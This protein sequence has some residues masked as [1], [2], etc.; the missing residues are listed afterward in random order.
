MNSEILE[1][2][3]ALYTRK[4]ENLVNSNKYDDEDSIAKLLDIITN[5]EALKMATVNNQMYIAVN[6]LVNNGE[7]LSSLLKDINVTDLLKSMQQR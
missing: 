2:L 1:K 6:D 3:E 7:G 4:L 5:I